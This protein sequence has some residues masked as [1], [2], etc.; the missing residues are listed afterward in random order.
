MEY[1]CPSCK[2]VYHLVAVFFETLH[3]FTAEKK[4]ELFKNILRSLVP[5]GMYIES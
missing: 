1:I 2:E 5:V 3:H 4:T